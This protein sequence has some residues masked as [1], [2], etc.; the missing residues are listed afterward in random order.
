MQD[1]DM[2]EM[3]EGSQLSKQYL[4]N[5]WARI[6]N[7][8]TPPQPKVAFGS[9]MMNKSSFN[10]KIKILYYKKVILKLYY[11]ILLKM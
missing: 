6:S 11:I 2:K 7:Y 5:Y 4:H 8:D 10:N 1:T 3:D 9:M